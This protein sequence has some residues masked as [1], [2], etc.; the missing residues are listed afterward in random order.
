ME[1]MCPSESAVLNTLF[2]GIEA[3]WIPFLTPNLVDL[4]GLILF[5]QGRLLIGVL[6]LS[7][8]QAC[9]FPDY[10]EYVSQRSAIAL[11]SINQTSE[12]IKACH[13]S[14]YW[15]EESNIYIA[16]KLHRQCVERI[17]AR[18]QSLR[19]GTVGYRRLSVPTLCF[20]TQQKTHLQAQTHV[21][22]HV[23][24]TSRGTRQPSVKLPCRENIAFLF[25]TL[26]PFVNSIPQDQ[27][28]WKGAMK[29]YQCP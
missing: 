13:P 18:H 1:G 21:S 17:S 12:S 22:Q 26:H 6:A 8:P 24:D 2:K 16:A 29:S 3:T 11:E 28:N 14:K 15:S 4:S 27:W 10:L 7:D 23:K 19:S 5:A 25:T 9:F 20:C